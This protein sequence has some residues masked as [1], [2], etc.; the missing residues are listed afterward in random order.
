MPTSTT[1]GSG[2]ATAP[3]DPNVGEHTGTESSL[4]NWAGP[5]VTD[6]LGKGWAA[7]DQP[8]QGYQGPLTAGTSN[9]QN[10]AFQG[11][12]NLAAPTGAMGAFDTTAAQNYMNPY[13]QSALQPQLAEMRR[14]S[15]ISGMADTSRLTKAGAYGGTRQAVMD[16]ERD[17]SLQANIGQATG[18]GYAKAFDKA[19][20]LFG[21]DRGYGLQALAAQ[22]A[23]GREERGIE[24]EGIAADRA[25]FEEERDFPYKQA[26]YMQSLL[27]DMPIAARSYNYAQPSALSNI[28]GNSNLLAEILAI[29]GGGDKKDANPGGGEGS[30]ETEETG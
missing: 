17:R 12:G 22:Q 28:L 16:A 9:L 24:Q 7:A 6:M 11:I 14:Q 18:A 3:T 20:D 29:Y 25:Q 5:Y 2:T 15:Q 26:Q 10:T 30:A 23:A 8:Y 19:A 21:R 4:S 27:Q 1:T 13:L